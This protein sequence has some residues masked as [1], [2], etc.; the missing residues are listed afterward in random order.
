MRQF[1]TFAEKRW[2]PATIA[3]R[4]NELQPLYKK[5][6]PAFRHRGLNKPIG[7]KPAAFPRSLIGSGEATKSHFSAITR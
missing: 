6:K 4:I 1:Y 7:E 3:D 5:Q 2:S